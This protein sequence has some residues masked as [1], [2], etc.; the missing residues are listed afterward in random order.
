MS[1]LDYDIPTKKITITHAVGDKPAV[2]V[3]VFGLTTGDFILLAQR[4]SKELGFLYYTTTR[5]TDFSADNS[6]SLVHGAFP[7]MAAACIVLGTKEKLTDDTVNHVKNYPGLIQAELLA[8]IFALSFTGDVKK[9]LQ[10]LA[11]IIVPL[12]KK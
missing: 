2:I 1:L 11:P 9:S 10:I 8:E 3:D 12:L 6:V 7:E 5:L 4:Y